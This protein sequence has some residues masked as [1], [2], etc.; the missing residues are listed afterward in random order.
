MRFAFLFSGKASFSKVVYKNRHLIANA[1]F[2]LA[3][4]DRPCEGIDFYINETE[5]PTALHEYN[6]FKSKQEFEEAVLKTLNE[7]KIDYLFLTYT[8]LI[9]KTLLESNL[10]NRIFNLHPAL[11]PMFKG[12]NA[13]EQ[14]YESSVLFY[15]STLHLTD[16]SMD[17]GPSLN[18]VIINRNLDDN[19]EAF[20][21]KLFRST[22]VMLIDSIYKIANDEIIET[23]QGIRYSKASY[24]SSPY[25][26]GLSFQSSQVTYYS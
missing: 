8:R 11:L 21:D 26:P 5:I 25:N 22:A 14:A 1:D 12:L 19:L 16:L 4:A 2:A 23:L 3:I 15:G 13:I 7:Y 9:G 6:S 24:G 18:Q 17:G 20:T 10:K